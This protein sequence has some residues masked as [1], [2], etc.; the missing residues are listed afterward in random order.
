MLLKDC[1]KENSFLT[2]PETIE[3]FRKTFFISDIFS[4]ETFNLWDKNGRKSLWEKARGKAFDLL[5]KHKFE[6]DEYEKREIERIWKKAVE[7]FS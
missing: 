6:R 3:K 4:N 5:K 1:L 7:K 2:H